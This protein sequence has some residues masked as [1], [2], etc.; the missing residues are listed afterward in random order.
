M[1]K[2]IFIIIAI[3]LLA[4]CKPEDEIVTTD[5]GVKLRFSTDTISFDTLLTSIGSVTKRFK[6]YNDDDNAIEISNINLAGGASS[7]Y[8]IIVNGVQQ[9]SHS[10]LLILGGDSVNILVEVLIDPMNNDLPYLVKDSITFL[11]NGNDQNVKLIAFG[12]D[13]HFLSDS[14]LSCGTTWTFGKPYV[15]VDS[16]TVPNGCN[17]TIEKGARV[18]FNT[19]ARLK[20]E[21]N[22]TVTGSKDSLVTF[23]NENEISLNPAKAFGYWKGIE[24]GASSTGN[25]IDYAVIKNAVNGMYLSSGN[26][27][28]SVAE[29]S[30]NSVIIK[31]MSETGITAYGA[32]IF[33]T[34]TV[35]TNCTDHLLQLLGGGNCGILHSTF[36]NYSFDFFRSGPSVFMNESDTEN[37]TMVSNTLKVAF[38]NSIVTGSFSEELDISISA[39]VGSSNSLF[40]TNDAIFTGNNNLIDIDPRFE[41]A[42]LGNFQ[43][44]SLSPLIDTG[45]VSFGTAQDILGNIRDAKP[46]VGAYEYIP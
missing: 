21:G 25:S 26:S 41:S 36:A 8:S 17:L 42:G 5:G 22:L 19:D 14:T 39:S 35:I 46:D 31:D 9:T 24:F 44:D 1:Q 37:G 38:I 2:F 45:N 43:L 12:Q 15:I 23:C 11:T 18:L 34:N 13:A 3:T 28:D 16:V 27:V 32:D 29:L 10:D 20:V 30:L 6:V 40:F 7:S 33:I 4:Q